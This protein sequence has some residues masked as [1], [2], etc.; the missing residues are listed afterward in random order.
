MNVILVVIDSLRADHVGCYGNTWIKTPNLDAFSKESAL[1]E[2]CFPESLPTVPARRAMV[3]GSRVFPF[4]EWQQDPSRGKAHAVPG[5][6][7]LRENDVTLSE[8]LK[9]AGYRT[10]FLTDVYHMF[11]PS[12]NFHRGFDEW[13]LIRGQEVDSYNSTPPPKDIDLDHFL[14]PGLVGTLAHTQLLQYFSNT[15]FRKGEEDYFAPLVFREGM[16]WLKENRDAEKFFL[17]IDSFDPHEPWDPPQ[18]YRDLYDPGY[19]GRECIFL[20]PGDPTTYMS[21]RELKHTRALYAAEV[22]MVD[23]WFGKFMAAVKELGLHKNTLILVVS[24]HGHPLGEHKT[25]RKLAWA[26]YPTLMDCPLL[27][28]H[29]EGIG[30]GKRVKEFVQHHDLLPTILSYLGVEPPEKIDGEDLLPLMTGQ[31]GPKRDHV[32]CGFRRYVWVRDKRYVL[33]SLTNKSYVRLFDLKNDPGNFK[34]VAPDHPEIVKEMYEKAVED[35]KGPLPLF[36]GLMD[37]S[38]GIWFPT[39]GDP[40]PG[41]IGPPI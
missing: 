2:R 10:A 12:M 31:G 11:K 38:A 4:R 13:R 39:P 35:V 28:R 37:Y 17:W 30:A 36:P 18:E 14:T 9:K 41:K 21:E 24:D 22:T 29:P 25:T 16:R 33:I 40:T 6:A 5:W 15:T 32:T 7:P 8:I 19:K 3:T 20:T 34:D 27:I 1:F 23:R 26:L